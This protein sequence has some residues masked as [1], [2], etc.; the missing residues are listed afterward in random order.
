[1]FYVCFLEHSELIPVLFRIIWVF[2]SS[3]NSLNLL[4]TFVSVLSVIGVIPMGDDICG[5]VVSCF[6]IDCSFVLGPGHLVYVCFDFLEPLYYTD[7]LVLF[8]LL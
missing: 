3:F 7:N 2:V 8:S 5:G 4:N 1:M 6:L